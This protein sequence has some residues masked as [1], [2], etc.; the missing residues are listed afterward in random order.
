MA[1]RTRQKLIE[2]ANRLAD[3]PAEKARQ[4]RVRDAP[5]DAVARERHPHQKVHA[6]APVTTHA[7][8]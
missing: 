6:T 3:E 8:A 2:E 1:R 7:R 5:P 4:Y